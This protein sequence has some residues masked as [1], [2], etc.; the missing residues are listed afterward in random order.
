MKAAIIGYGKMGREIERILAERGHETAL[1]IDTDNASEL[2]AA[3]LAG[4]DAAIEFTTP[5][6]AYANIRTCIEAGTP[7]VSGTTGWTDRLPELQELCR[8]RG[9]AMFYASNYCLGVNLLFRLNRQLAA[10]L[11]RLGASYDVRIEEVHHTQKK[12]A[13]S[14]TAITLAEGVIDNLS[15]KKSWVN[16]APGIGCA[17][18]RIGDPAEAAPDQLVI[19]SVREGSVPGIHTVSYESEDDILEL[20]HTIKN[21]RSLAFGAVVAAEFLCGKKGVFGMEDLMK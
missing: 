11:E 19:G 3:H 18:N 9:G 12:D 5:Q 7:V 17:A 13:P 8:Q 6:T 2:D 20:R 15:T 21:R 10:M 1:V 14:G 4:I 16:H